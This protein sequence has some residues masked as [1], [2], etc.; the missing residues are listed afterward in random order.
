MTWLVIPNV[1]EGRDAR[2]IASMRTTVEQHGGR[3]LDVHSDPVHHRSVF[4]VTGS[5]SE[6]PHSMAGL[7]TACQY[8]DLTHHVGV[9]PRLGRLDVCPIVGLDEPHEATLRIAHTTG[10]E[11][12]ARTGL[13]I[14]FYGH[15]AA[16]EAAR[17]LPNIRRGGLKS[18]IERALGELPPDIGGP[19]IQPDAGVVCVGVREVLIAFNVWLRCDTEMAKAIAGRVRTT[20]GGASGIRALGLS[21]DDK[22][23]SQVSMN[24]IRPDITGIDAAFESVAAEAA[25][26]HVQV[27]ATEI[28]GLVP[29]RFLPNPNA[30]AARLLI[31]PGRSVE[32]SLS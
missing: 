2:R 18:L 30:E 1:S 26:L 25:R 10:A 16:R 19:A 4:T 23:T 31:Q 21:I 11:I 24:L 9:H 27:I 13:P 28:V 5:A 20:G 7:A 8:I 22:P 3:V 15:A 14:Y 6:L 17:D 12:H 32:N 29:E